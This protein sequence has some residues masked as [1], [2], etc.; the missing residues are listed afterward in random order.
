M[1]RKGQDLYKRMAIIP[2][3]GLVNLAKHNYK[4]GEYTPLDMI[5]YKY[6][7]DPVLG[8]IPMKMAPNLITILGFVFA[9][10][11]IIVLFHVNP[12]LD[13]VLP[14][15]YP[16]WGCVSFLFYMMMD[17]IDGRQARRTKSGSPL[18]QL[19]DH[20]CD[21]ILSGVIAIVLASTLRVGLGFELVVLIAV[22]QVVFFIGQWEENYTGI[23]RTCV[24]GLF[25][26]TEY[27]LGFCILQISV[28]FFDDI[29]LIRSLV[30]IGT[31]AVGIA[32]SLYCITNVLVNTPRI[33]TLVPLVPLVLL[34]ILF[35]YFVSSTHFTSFVPFL[36]LTLLNSLLVIQMILSTVTKLPI[37]VATQTLTILPLIC[38]IP[39]SNEYLLLIHTAI[40]A[41]Y[42]SQYIVRAVL[43]IS[44]YLNIKVF[45]IYFKI[46]LCFS[47]ISS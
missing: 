10:S 27:L 15:I 8:L 39:L 33:S 16:T 13:R 1:G 6:W 7:W 19:L 29:N 44:H 24:L 5:C 35:G 46:C 45:T 36:S 9:L 42:V 34:N 32:S 25:G 38:L 41:L 14:P 20:G 11:N 2:N 4:G 43:Q 28:I 18:G 37:N 26:T 40:V 23:C 47:L 12:S 3:R 30:F 31:V 17:A 21:S 22:S